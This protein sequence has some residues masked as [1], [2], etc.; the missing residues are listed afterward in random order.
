M[1]ALGFMFFVIMVLYVIWSYVFKYIVVLMSYIV[2]LAVL[3]M[4]E[5][6]AMFMTWLMKNL[7]H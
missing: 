5:V 2:V 4:S 3:C 1:I 7:T 6:N